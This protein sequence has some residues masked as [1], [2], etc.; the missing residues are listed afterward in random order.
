MKIL[1]ICSAGA[2]RSNYLAFVLKGMGHDAL[3]AGIDMNKIET[4]EF[5]GNWADMIVVAEPFMKNR[6]PASIQSKV[7]DDLAIGPDVW[8]DHTPGELIASCR[9]VAARIGSS[10]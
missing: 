5:L 3:A 6:L 2:K 8:P 7:R 4:I 9:F 10:N 1:C